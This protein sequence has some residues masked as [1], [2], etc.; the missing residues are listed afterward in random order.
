MPHMRHF[1]MGNF[2]LKKTKVIILYLFL[3][4]DGK[5]HTKP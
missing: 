4:H 1:F 3:L 2:G 5:I